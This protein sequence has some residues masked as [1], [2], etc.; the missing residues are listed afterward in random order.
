M[1][2]R[3]LNVFLIS[4][5]IL[6]A[7]LLIDAPP[8]SLF[9]RSVF[10]IVALTLVLAGTLSIFTAFSGKRKN[11]KP[12]E[13]VTK[14]GIGL[15]LI[16]AFIMLRLISHMSLMGIITPTKFVSQLLA[17]TQVSIVLTYFYIQYDVIKSLKSR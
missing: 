8:S 17:I 2:N 11:K 10:A 16:S 5:F 6:F 14:L 12:N 4:E 15:I 9:Y 1:W 7:L 3:Y 13:I